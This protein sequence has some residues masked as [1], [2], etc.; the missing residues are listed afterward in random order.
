MSMNNK[1][2]VPDQEQYT[3]EN[4]VEAKRILNIL[5]GYIQRLA[6]NASGFV[7]YIGLAKPGTATSEAK[8]QIKKLT[9]S[10]T[11]VTEINFADGNLNFDKEWDEKASYSYS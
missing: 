4:A 8:W 11:N 6:Y 5:D 2:A 1:V 3:Y 9:Y 7:E 10:G